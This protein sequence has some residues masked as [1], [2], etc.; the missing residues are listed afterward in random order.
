[1]VA[2]HKLVDVRKES[3]A[4]QSSVSRY[5]AVCVLA[6]HGKRCSLYVADRNLKN[7]FVGAVINRKLHIRL[8]D[9]DVPHDPCVIDVQLF[10]VLLF[11]L[12]AELPHKAL[13]GKLLV[14]FF[15]RPQDRL[16]LLLVKIGY[17]FHIGSHCS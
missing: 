4:R 6:A 9:A 5:H 2:L 8:R 1:M 15:R 10:E 12:L 3:G 14:I 17:R 16:I 7:R 13:P 11:L